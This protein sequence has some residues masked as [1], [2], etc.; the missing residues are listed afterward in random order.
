MKKE[1]GEKLASCCRKT[2]PGPRQ[3]DNHQPSQSS[4]CPAQVVSVAV[5]HVRPRHSV[6][7]IRLIQRTVD[8]GGCPVVEAQW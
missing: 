5:K 8:A 7:P 3:P 1:E 4:V 2:A 6:L